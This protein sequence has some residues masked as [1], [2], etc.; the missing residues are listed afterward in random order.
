MIGGFGRHHESFIDSS[1]CRPPRQTNYTTRHPPVERGGFAIFPLHID[2]QDTPPR[3]DAS[4]AAV[5]TS[6]LALEIGGG[7]LALE[8]LPPTTL[9][10]STAMSQLEP[11]KTGDSA[12]PVSTVAAGMGSTSPVPP[13]SEP[14][15]PAQPADLGHCRHEMRPTLPGPFPSPARTAQFP[16]RRW[17]T[18][19]SPS[20]PRPK[21]CE[22]T[23]K[24]RPTK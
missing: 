4:A 6:C 23:R 7:R 18:A 16:H 11:T 5:S 13:A 14:F 22:P 19:R 12:P 10:E 8:P 21:R 15:P 17:Q 3:I 1:S 20:R 24:N 9:V 2:E